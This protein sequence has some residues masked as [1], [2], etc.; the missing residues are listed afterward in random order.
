MKKSMFKLFLLFV[1]TLSLVSC[2]PDNGI[3]AKEELEELGYKVEVL[4]GVKA[5][6]L[7]FGVDGV[8]EAVI[9]AKEG[10]IFT[11]ILFDSEDYAEKAISDIEET[12]GEGENVT[13]SGKW[14]FIGSDAS[15]DAKEV[16]E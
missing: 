14:L 3:E 2:K 13:Q 5:D 4:T 1:L 15:K 11:A 8:N 7:Y 12:L 10:A 6:A 9:G 16:F